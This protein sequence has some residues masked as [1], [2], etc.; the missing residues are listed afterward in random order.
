LHSGRAVLKAQPDVNTM[1][2]PHIRDQIASAIAMSDIAILHSRD[3]DLALFA[4]E[5][6]R[7]AR[8]PV[9]F[10][11]SEKS[12]EIVAKLGPVLKNADFVLAPG[13]AM[14]PGMKK[15]DAHEL[16]GRLVEM[17]CDNFAISDNSHPILVYS[18]GEASILEVRKAQEVDV[19]C[20]GDTRDAV[21]AYFLAGG[22]DFRTALEK[23]SDI[24]SLS[25]EHYGRD[26]IDH[27][28]AHINASPLYEND[29]PATPGV[30]YAIA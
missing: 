25:V 30:E 12:P 7:E 3:P 19:L 10:D 9:L 8:I 17:G 14:V 6:A 23:G 20:A 2:C 13:D 18:R 11:C 21:T 29:R 22:Q 27:L 1:P 5:R 16:F 15:K 26:W 28:Q 4:A 24:A